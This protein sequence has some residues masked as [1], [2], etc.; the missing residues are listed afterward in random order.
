MCVCVLDTTANCAKTAEPI[1]MLSGKQTRVDLTITMYHIGSR[2]PTGISSFGYMCNEVW[3]CDLLPNYFRHMLTTDPDDY[4]DSIL[5]A[6][7]FQRQTRVRGLSCGVIYVILGLA[8]LI[9][10]RSV[11]D[12]HTHTETH[13]HGK[14]RIAACGN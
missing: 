5:Q 3:R 4:P 9:Q 14:I 10:Y 13:D 7:P 11:M 2:S 12:T 6:S 1:E 8:I